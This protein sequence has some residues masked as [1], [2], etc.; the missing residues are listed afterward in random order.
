CSRSFNSIALSG[1]K[2][3]IH[4]RNTLSVRLTP[5]TGLWATVRPAMLPKK[6][7][8]RRA[9]LNIYPRCDPKNSSSN[10]KNS[11]DFAPAYLSK[12][13]W[14]S[15]RKVSPHLN[16]DKITRAGC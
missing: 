14:L 9:D 4:S 6:C 7:T 12:G 1:G 15:E 8:G 11:E 10:D 3:I 16:N 5:P 2:S 13:S